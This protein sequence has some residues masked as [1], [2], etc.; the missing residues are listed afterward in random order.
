MIYKYWYLNNI[1]WLW[2]KW[3]LSSEEYIKLYKKN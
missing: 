2:I 3:L 1:I